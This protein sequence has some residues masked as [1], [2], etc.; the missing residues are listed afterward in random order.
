MADDVG[1]TWADFRKSGLMRAQRWICGYS[2]QRRRRAVPRSN[3]GAGLPR[4]L[5]SISSRGRSSAALRRGRRRFL[6]SFMMSSFKEDSV[7]DRSGGLQTLDPAGNAVSEYLSR[8]LARETPGRNVIE[9]SP[10]KLRI[11]E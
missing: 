7:F 3:G 9:R 8:I 1:G 2:S 5:F 10:I 4:L 11:N 6:D